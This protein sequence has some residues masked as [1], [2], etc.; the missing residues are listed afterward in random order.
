MFND[1]LLN[2]SFEKH[3]IRVIY[4]K[5]FDYSDESQYSDFKEC[6]DDNSN[7]NK[8]H[9]NVD[10]FCTDYSK[11]FPNI[12]EAKIIENVSTSEI[13]N[14]LYKNTEPKKKRKKKKR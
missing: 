11:L 8:Q 9:I 7:E 12:P 6:D 14:N 1:D 3:Y 5:E 13:T 4:G 10:D 2:Q